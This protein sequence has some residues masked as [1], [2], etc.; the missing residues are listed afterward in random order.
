MASG[1]VNAI[2]PEKLVSEDAIDVDVAVTGVAI[3]VSATQPLM[4]SPKIR[5]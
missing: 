3:G 5:T 2:E 1:G 4:L